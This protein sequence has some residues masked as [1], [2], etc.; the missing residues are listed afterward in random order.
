MSTFI[1][2]D[3]KGIADPSF[4]SSIYKNLKINETAPF[5]QRGITRTVRCGTIEEVPD[6]RMKL[7]KLV[8]LQHAKV[9]IIE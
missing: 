3:K 4:D 1:V 8:T 9:L 5:I 2:Y 7:A 6:N